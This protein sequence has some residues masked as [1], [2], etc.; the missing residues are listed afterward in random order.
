MA[1]IAYTILEKTNYEPREA[2][3]LAMDPENLFQLYKN[4]RLSNDS[5]IYVT[6]V[7]FKDYSELKFATD[8]SAIY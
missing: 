4:D 8:L 7:R 1:S 6:T 5:D 3:R 2:F